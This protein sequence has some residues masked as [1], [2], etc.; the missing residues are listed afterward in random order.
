MNHT[1]L[2]YNRCCERLHLKLQNI[3]A[4]LFSKIFW[5]TSLCP[6]AYEVEKP[7]E[8]CFRGRI[9]ST[10]LA[11]IRLELSINLKHGHIDYTKVLRNHL[12]TFKLIVCPFRSDESRLSFL[13]R[14]SLREKLRDSKTWSLRRSSE[15]ELSPS[16]GSSSSPAHH[17]SS[18][19]R[20]SRLFSLRRSLGPGS[21]DKEASQ[22]AM[23]RLAEEDD[24]GGVKDDKTSPVPCLPPTPRF[25]TPEQ[26]K[27]RHIVNS[28]VAS[29]NNYLSSLRRLVRDYKVPLEE[30]SPP[31]LSQAKVDIL[32]HK[33]DAI[34]G[35]HQQFRV[36][37]A[38]AVLQW[39]KVSVCNWSNQSEA[40]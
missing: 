36:A 32:F 8:C 19:S 23:P 28:L 37:L 24:E 13:K 17:D 20:L 6:L 9:N 12:V 33:L 1:R 3:F 31:I 15:K 4:Q 2:Q 29:E 18:E 27:R 34:L 14:R 7:I 11:K 30:S 5:P 26:T 16:P 25:L 40:I 10:T 21:S 38:E 39:D 22:H 35:C